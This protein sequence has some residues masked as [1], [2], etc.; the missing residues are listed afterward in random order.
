MRN[1][2]KLVLNPSE[3]RFWQLCY[4]PDC[5]IYASPAFGIPGSLLQAPE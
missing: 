2:I 1:G 3:G 5:R 4:D